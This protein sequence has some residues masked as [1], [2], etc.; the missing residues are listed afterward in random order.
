MRAF[1][2]H[3]HGLRLVSAISLVFCMS[4][5]SQAPAS[6]RIAEN[7]EGSFNSGGISSGVDP[8]GVRRSANFAVVD[9]IGQFAVDSSANPDWIVEHGCWHSETPVTIVSGLPS[10]KQYAD[11]QLISISSQS[12]ATAG[13]NHFSKRFYV[14]AGD[15]SSGLQVRYGPAGGTS[16][17]PGDMVSVTGRL[18]TIDGERLIEFP[19]V[20]TR[21]TGNDVPAPAFMACRSLGGGRLSTYTPGV[22]NGVGLNNVG[23]LVGILGRAQSVDPAGEFFYVEDGSHLSDGFSE[24]VRVA[25]TDLAPGQAITPPSEHEFVVVVGISSTT[26]IGSDAVRCVRPRDQEDITILP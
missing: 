3:C 17:A 19:T 8:D 4:L 2:P 26:L 18:A 21:S 12:V 14:Q 22:Q 13:T 25:L 11:G 9:S 20:V 15:R 16:I 6:D 10:A 23:L 7:W 24:G 5:H 1:G